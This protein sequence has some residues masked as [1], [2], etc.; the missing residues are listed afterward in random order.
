MTDNNAS[1]DAEL[2]ANLT[3][4]KREELLRRAWMANDGLWF[5]EAAQAL[6]IDKANEANGRVVHE[7]ARLE[8]SRLMRALNVRS[9]ETVEQYAALFALAAEVYVGSLIEYDDKIEDGKHDMQ[10]RKCFAYLGV[11]RAG[12][13]KLYRCGPGARIEGWIEAMGLSDTVEP[14]VGLCQ[15][16]HKGSCSYR[17]N[18]SLPTAASPRGSN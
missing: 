3:A 5:Y 16:A 1:S 4:S 8:M 6:G 2:G 14:E 7:F 9:V 18:V 11:R 12:I 10:V 17:I 15:M 13:E